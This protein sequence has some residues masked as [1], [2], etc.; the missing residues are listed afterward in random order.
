MF[1]ADRIAKDIIQSGKFKPYWV[2]DMKTPSGRIH[3]GGLRAVTT[4]DIVYKALLDAGGKAKFT[5]VFD[6]HDPMDSLPAYLPKDFEQ[7]LGMPLFMIPSPEKGFK[8]YAQY[9]AKD[10]QG[11]FR[12]ID[13][14]P[15]IIWTTDLYFSGK[16][17]EGIK[18]C[19]DNADKIRRIY[20][21]LYKKKMADDWYPFNVY[22]PQCNKVSTTK[23]VDWDGKEI[24]FEC[25]VAA[26]AWTK[27]CG[28]KGKIS[29]F[30]TKD[31]IN[32]KLPWKVEWAVKWQ[33]IGVTIEGAGK[34]HMTA[35]GS[36]DLAKRVAEEILNYPTPYAF[37]H[38][39]FLV[40]GRKMSTSKG[41]G[42]SVAELLEILPAELVRFLIVKTKLNQAINFD[43]TGDTIPDLFDDYQETSISSNSDLKRI[44][45]LSQ[46]G[47]KEK[48]P[49]VRFRTLAQ[50]IQMPNME[51][52][53]KKAVAEHWA[54]YAKVWLEKYA[55][56]D[57]KFA[58]Q[59]GL[60]KD[61]KKLSDEQKQ[62]LLRISKELDKKWEGE[63]FQT[64][65][66]E[67]GK[68]LELNGAKTFEAIYL[69]LLGKDHGPKAAWLI[70]SL[71]KNFVKKR[72]QEVQK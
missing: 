27:G 25:R 43:P 16:M 31:K 65:I 39:F 41:A 59:K 23:T 46:V 34:D 22:C 38:E 44:F 61:V 8:D 11:G 3:V 45:E 13:C 60:P 29:P 51:E 50:W 55:P 68:E 47:E 63:D 72:F 30:A 40:G 19:L 48:V 14:N 62:L 10:F 66:Y 52:E 54:K 28:Y 64:R 56:E 17:N 57:E 15:E 70:L 5:Y 20:E 35:G 21:D 26:V 2:D 1:W 69:S 18:K 53:I 32:G 49:Q 67:I 36:H 42:I 4:H 58:I 6:N 71:D 7:Y 12:K 37:A 24:T 9:Y 33:A